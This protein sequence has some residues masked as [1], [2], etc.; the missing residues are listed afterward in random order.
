MSLI[1]ECTPSAPTSAS[2]TAE[3]HV[4]LDFAGAPVAVVPR[5]RIKRLLAQSLLQPQSAQHLH[6]V[7]ADLDA[8][9]DPGELRR[10]L[11]HRDVDT[12]APQCRGG[13]KPAHAGADDRDR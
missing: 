10:L 4:E 3:D 8:G 7:A 9:A 2:A 13:C 12:H 5:A 1:R 6:R 11:V